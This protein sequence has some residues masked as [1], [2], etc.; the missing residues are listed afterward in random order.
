[1]LLFLGC[2]AFCSITPAVGQEPILSSS[3]QLIAW[4]DDGSG[5]SEFRFN[6]RMGW[7]HHLTITASKLRTLVTSAMIYANSNAERFPPMASM[8]FDEQYWYGD[9]PPDPCTFYS[10][11]DSDPA[12]TTINNDAINADNSAQISFRYLG[13]GLGSEDAGAIIFE[14]IDDAQNGGLGRYVAYGNGQVSFIPSDP[15]VFKDMYLALD[16]CRTGT[17][18]RGADNTINE[19]TFNLPPDALMESTGKLHKLRMRHEGSI[20]DSMLDVFDVEGWGTAGNSV[21]L[22]DQYLM[23]FEDLTFSGPDQNDMP[24]TFYSSFDT[25]VTVPMDNYQ[26]SSAMTMSLSWQSHGEEPDV[27]RD[28]GV[29][30]M[31]PFG[32]IRF[33][34]TSV[35]D[36][37]RLQPGEPGYLHGRDSYRLRGVCQMTVE[38]PVDVRAYMNWS[39]SHLVR[40]AVHTGIAAGDFMRADSTFELAA[41][42]DPVDQL[43]MYLPPNYGLT[44]VSYD[45]PPDAI[46]PYRRGDWDLNHIVGPTDAAGFASAFTGPHNMSLEC[47]DDLQVFDFDG[48][49]DID[50]HDYVLFAE[51][52]DLPPSML[53]DLPQCEETYTITVGV[54]GFGGVDV[55]PHSGPFYAGERAWIIAKPWGSDPFVEWQ[56]DLSGTDPVAIVTVNSDLNITAVFDTAC[57][58]EFEA[59]GVCLGPASDPETSGLLSPTDTVYGPI[60]HAESFRYPIA[61]QLEGVRWYG[62]YSG[63]TG[64]PCTADGQADQ[65]VVNIYDDDSGLPGDLLASYDDTT[66]IDRNPTGKLRA[67]SILLNP[68]AEYRYMLLFDAPFVAQADTTYWVEIRNEHTQG[69]GEP[70]FWFW[71]LA[72]GGDDSSLADT[73]NDGYDTGD[74]V[75]SD[76]TLCMLTFDESNEDCNRNGLA[77]ACE[78]EDGSATDCNDNQIPD[79]CESD[80]LPIVTQHPQNQSVDEGSPASFT[81]EAEGT[82]ISYRWQKNGNYIPGA[83]ESTYTIDAAELSDAG[84]YRAEI[85][86]PCGNVFSNNATLSVQEMY[87]L[88]VDIDGQGNVILNPPGGSYSAGQQV[89]LTA[90]PATNWQF[91]HW[92]GAASGTSPNTQVVMNSDK[93]VRAIFEPTHTLTISVVG[94]G[95]VDVLAIPE[96]VNGRYA[97]GAIVRLTPN[98]DAGWFF[99]GWS[100]GASGNA[101]PLTISMTGDRNIIATFSQQ[102]PDTFTITALIIGQGQVVFDQPGGV[103]PAGETAT[104]DAVPAEGWY[105]ERWTGA[106]NDTNTQTQIAMNANQVVVAVFRETLPAGDEN[107]ETPGDQQQPDLPD[108]LPEDVQDLIEQGACGECAN[109]AAA[110]TLG[111]MLLLAPMRFGLRRSRRRRR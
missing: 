81:V 16:A 78:I 13:A 57:G 102:A 54:D 92:E 73:E 31:L 72:T 5:G 56:G 37:S 90:V 14:E 59:S 111:S 63:F 22:S 75:E 104:I 110:A 43:K 25:I 103:Y 95:N 106:I 70:C 51:A 26:C 20:S 99:T 85:V 62:G 53:P 34:N 55:W 84:T 42:G 101:A 79:D 23:F 105:F 66:Y 38:V 15:H 98:P 17:I 69:S 93:S 65:F 40:R 91:D 19:Y 61:T 49:G 80:L 3:T 46:A 30:G 18:H 60:P 87:S 41:T 52:F 71:S 29:A 4:D 6:A 68:V 39:V 2:W 89:T 86:S 64:D 11:G 107:P 36:V 44:Q 10:M 109:G 35:L 77:D 50:C 76:L 88:D 12:P 94:Q 1:M 82:T 9:G 97:H 27:R 100:G 48:D 7:S 33:G 21:Q 47:F 32:L 96:P 67:P 108:D 58:I 28:Y 24:V 45:V 8:L 74:L 83:T